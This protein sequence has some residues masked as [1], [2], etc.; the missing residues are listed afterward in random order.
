MTEK[1][2]YPRVSSFKKTDDFRAHLEKVDA[3][4][5]C[6]DAI[7]TAPA[8]PLAQSAE[9]GGV[10]IGNRFAIQPMEGWDGN[11]KG[12]PSDLT[13][14]RWRNF[15][16]SGAKLIWGGKLSRSCRRGAPIRTN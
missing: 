9:V 5:P 16:L 1:V 11:E 8:S 2:R 6:D 12:E 10:R 4:M 3:V 15:G 13:R 7:E 14:R